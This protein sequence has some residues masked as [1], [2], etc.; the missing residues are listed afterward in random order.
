MLL[1]L[2]IEKKYTKP[3]IRDLTMST[4]SVFFTGREMKR[5]QV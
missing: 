5:E 2:R 1:R 3:A 4:A